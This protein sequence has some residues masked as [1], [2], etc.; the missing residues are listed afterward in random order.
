MYLDRVK[1][2]IKAGDGGNGKTSFHTEKFVRKGGPDGG[3]GGKGGD[4][5]FEATRE[6]DSLVDFRFTKHFRAEAGENGGSK[7]CTGKSGKELVIKVPLGTVIRDGETGKF[8]ADM[9]EDGERL[10][11]LKG[12][13]G[14]KGNARFKSSRLQAPAFS[15]TGQKTIERSVWLELKTIADVGLVGFP[16]VGKSTMLSMLTNARPKIANYHFTTLSPNLGV[17]KM[18]DKSFVIAD[19]P[20]LIE[21]ASEGEGLG[22]YFLRHIERTRCLVHVIDVS[23]SEDRD[24]YNDY[25]IIMSELKKYG[26][27]VSSLPQVVALNKCDLATPEQIKTVK[28]KIKRLKN[29]P[30]IFEISAVSNQGLEALIAHVSSMLDQIPKKGRTDE[31][32][33]VFTDPDK[34]RYEIINHSCGLFEVVGGYIDELIRGIVVSDPTSFAYF[35]KT[36]KE[37][38]I[39]KNILKQAEEDKT[40]PIRED[41][42]KDITIRIGGLDFDY[43]E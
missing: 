32:V 40:V 39:I 12:G 18:H 42:S 24:P 26:E 13:L 16:N 38:G 37:K 1:I 21:G 41:G 5:V 17:V 33:F 22:H 27:S 34:N 20:G 6:L 14:G 2:N 8:M 43:V 19:I 30:E 35:Q 28:S 7:N 10:V 31:E 25:K 15:M 23:G 3:D 4:I 11:I 9:I 36:I 29:A